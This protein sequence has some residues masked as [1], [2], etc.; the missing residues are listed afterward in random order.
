MRTPDIGAKSVTS[1]FNTQPMRAPRRRPE[2]K[3]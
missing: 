1:L 3:E 2:I